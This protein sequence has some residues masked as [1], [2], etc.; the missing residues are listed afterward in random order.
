MSKRSSRLTF[1]PCNMDTM[2]SF[3]L[4]LARHTHLALTQT[5]KFCHAGHE[6]A[7]EADRS[8]SVKWKP[9]SENSIDFK[10]VLR[11]PPCAFDPDKPDFHAKPVFL[12]HVWCGGPAYE[13]YDEMYVEDDEWET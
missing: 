9:P 10:L 1:L 13:L 5:C 3:T 2:A 6:L 7:P 12:L 4:V 11:F 8:R